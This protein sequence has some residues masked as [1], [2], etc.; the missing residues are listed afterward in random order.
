M[1]TYG[2]TQ[3]ELQRQ[4][5]SV[6]L[7][8]LLRECVIATVA[9]I[10]LAGLNYVFVIQR[11][12]EFGVLNALGF[13]RRQLVWRVVRETAVTVVAAWVLSVAMCAAGLL[14]VENGLFAP[15]GSGS[16]SSTRLPGCML[17]RY[18]WLSSRS[19]AAPLHGCSQGSIL[20]L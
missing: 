15:W 4:E 5:R 11:Q 13:A 20:W 12:S 8:F 14:T 7:T 3:G 16:A 1:S 18:L 9:D 6:L 19:A 17:S 10:A 2:K